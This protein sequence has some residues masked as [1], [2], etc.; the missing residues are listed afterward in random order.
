MDSGV[1]LSVAAD[2]QTGFESDFNLFHITGSGKV[3]SWQNLIR[4]DLV[5]WR[6]TAL[7]DENSLQRDPLFVDPDGADNVLGFANSAQDGRDDD[8]HITSQNG[9]FHGGA[10]APVRDAGSGLPVFLVPVVTNDGT[11]SAAL[12]RGDDTDDFANEPAFNGNYVN[13][14]AYGNTEQASK[15]PTQYVLVTRPDGGETWP[16][17]QSFTIRWRSHDLT[18]TVD[19]DLME[20]GNGTP[21]LSIATGEANDGEFDWLV[22]QS[23]TPGTNYEIRISRGAIVDSSDDVFSITAPITVYY[24]ND[25]SVNGAGDWTTAPGNDVNDGLTPATPK[26]TIASVLATYTLVPGNVIR[27]DDGDFLVSSNILLDANDH[28]YT[29]EGYHDAA[30]PERRALLDRSNTSSSAYVFQFTGADDV[31]LEH[32]HITGAYRGIFANTSANSDNITIANNEI[33]GNTNTN[34]YFQISNE[35]WLITGNTIHRAFNTSTTGIFTNGL[36]SQIIGN[37]IYSISFGIQASLSGS[38]NPADAILVSG[39]FIHHA[40]RQFNG[41]GIVAGQNTV[42]EGNTIFGMNNGFGYAMS[43]SSTAIARANVVHGNY[44]GI[45][46]SSTTLLENNEVFNN[47]NLGIRGDQVKGNRVYNNR[48]GIQSTGNNAVV[49][50]NLVYNNTDYGISAQRQQQR[51]GSPQHGDAD[52]R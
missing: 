10:L 22:P 29:I 11:T 33:Y 46:G 43:L 6:N 26:A 14:G 40:P 35:D 1:A 23:V 12:D 50:H 34:I 8:F 28:G 24:V 16:Q 49:E 51:G 13:I 37:D 9:S 2:S 19:I 41:N 5:S 47:A 25:G 39:N 31:S 18:G 17:D 20:Q 36:R 44:D 15:S 45:L 27:V 48:F 52:R 3:A 4:T 32:L 7:Q 42:V 38:T 21:V 30:Y